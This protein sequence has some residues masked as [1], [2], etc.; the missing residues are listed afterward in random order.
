MRIYLQKLV[1]SQTTSLALLAQDG[2]DRAVSFS[3]TRGEINPV[4]RAEG[5][6]ARAI[7]GLS[8]LMRLTVET[9]LSQF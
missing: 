3:E 4:C 2:T 6:H 5:A 7:P 9:L 8:S 1:A